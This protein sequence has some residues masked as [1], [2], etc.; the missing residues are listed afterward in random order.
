M[1]YN[2]RVPE[3]CRSF[4]KNGEL[5]FE[6]EPKGLAQDSQ[7]HYRAAKRK[8]AMDSDQDEPPVNNG[9]TISK[10]IAHGTARFTPD[11]WMDLRSKAKDAHQD[12]IDRMPE[13]EAEEA[14]TAEDTPREGGAERP[15][16]GNSGIREGA[17]DVGLLRFSPNLTRIG[18][19]SMGLPTG[20][21]RKERDR[22]R[23]A[24]D[25]GLPPG[26]PSFDSR[27]PGAA[28]IKQAW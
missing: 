23:L 6:Y 2:L 5:Y 26:M 24:L 12:C 21:T 28:R 10:M 25:A 9:A 3:G 1:T 27:F 19:D 17:A 14:D 11:D 13:G 16:L 7:A 8:P 20:P 22:A 4:T 18:T 15:D